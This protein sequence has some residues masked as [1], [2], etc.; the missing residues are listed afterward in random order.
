MSKPNKDRYA[1]GAP[2]I[3]A[4]DY[5][6]PLRT[7]RLQPPAIGIF[8]EPTRCYKINLE[9]A[10]HIEGAIEILADWTAWLGEDDERNIAVQQIRE[11]LKGTVCVDCN[12]VLNC[13]NQNPDWIAL[14]SIT[15][16]NMSETTAEF[17][18]EL[19][20]QYDGNPNSINPAIPVTEPDLAKEENALC[21]AIGAWVRLYCENKKVAIRQS[22]FL[23]QAWNA[24]QNAIEGAYGVI[25]NVTGFNLL[26]DLFSCFVDNASALTALD[27]ES[28]KTDII[29]C[30]YGELKDIA[31]LENSLEGAINACLGSLV[32]TAHDLLCL[33]SND[34]NLQHVLNF[35]YIYGRA[36][37]RQQSGEILECE[38]ESW[39]YSYIEYDFSISDWG[40]TVEGGTHVPGTGFV[41]TTY[42]TGSGNSQTNLQIRKAFSGG[43]LPRELGAGYI[44]DT[45]GDCGAGDQTVFYYLDSVQVAAAGIGGVGIGDN[46]FRTFANGT[47]PA[48]GRLA[49]EF[50]MRLIATRCDGMEAIARIKKV[51]VWLDNT[52]DLQGIPS[53]IAPVTLPE[54]GSTDLVYWQ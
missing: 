22:S 54:S 1:K 5:F 14:Q 51:R 42:L 12:D 35:F 23:S 18:A 34:L 21:F 31:L 47:V 13:L 2:P 3:A 37:D 40:F 16:E 19:E 49:D 20:T 4:K 25:S 36:L 32:G 7:Q 26:D 46:Q 15:I 27:D 52:G 28:A 43:A 29:C 44:I 41:G 24:L 9:W 33:I 39:D 30:L 53:D 50:H 11:L 8:D 38:C 45:Y 10:S 17:F 6:N 48:P